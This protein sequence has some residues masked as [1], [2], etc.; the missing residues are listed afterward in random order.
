MNINR[1]NYEAFFLDYYDGGLSPV[2]VAEM[3]VF[4][5]E[6]PDLENIFEDYKEIILSGGGGVF[7][8]KLILKKKYTES[9]IETILASEIT[10]DN[11]NHF[12]IVEMEGILSSEQKNRLDI[13]LL[14]N[15]EL[16]NVYVLFQKCK[17]Q[18]EA[19]NFEEKQ[20][21]KQEI[22]TTENYEEFFV[23]V[24]D[25][26]LKEYEQKAL[27]VFL[28]KHI[29]LK[30]EYT[31]FSKTIL[32]PEKFYFEN[33]QSLKKKEEKHPIL[34]IR[35]NSVAY[36]AAAAGILLLIGLF[37]MF[38]NENKSEPFY[39]A[40]QQMNITPSNSINPPADNKTTTSSDT[41]SSFPV[42]KLTNIVETNKRVNKSGIGAVTTHSIHQEFVPVVNDEEDI[43]TVQS[44]PIK[45][46]LMEEIDPEIIIAERK[47]KQKVDAKGSSF[48]SATGD[49]EYPTIKEALI[50]KIKRAIGSNKSNMCNQDNSFGWWDVAVAAKTGIQ[51]IVGIKSIEVN[52]ICNDNEGKVEYVFTAGNFQFVKSKPTT[53]VSEA[54]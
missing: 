10:K 36:Y 7:P 35:F 52:K 15:P 6:N 17:L 34:I 54:K 25:K 42:S 32:T 16:K 13:F 22:I 4:L 1:N 51:N 53:I 29:E 18:A 19:I 33:K 38:H 3:L 26:D 37:F 14:K 41:K 40:Q 39:A 9:E 31:L 49:E 47:E 12:F 21:L 5:Q 46:Q 2:E 50:K 43:I 11:C 44:E 45:V 23:R 28:Q 27:T 48:D 20:L 8:E 24:I 30:K